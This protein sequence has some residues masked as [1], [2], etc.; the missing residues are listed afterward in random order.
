MT[1]NTEDNNRRTVFYDYEIKQETE[2]VDPTHWIAGC[3]HT[4]QLCLELD[5]K[6]L[7]ILT[8]TATLTPWEDVAG[9]LSTD[10]EQ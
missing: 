2:N 1:I 8:V 6:G 7:P 10:L 4:Y 5:D 9:S 3:I